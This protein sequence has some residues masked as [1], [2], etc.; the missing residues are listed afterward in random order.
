MRWFF[1]LLGLFS[2][3]L[4]W[5]VTKTPK[6]TIVL[7]DGSNELELVSATD[8]LDM[9]FRSYGVI[10]IRLSANPER[11]KEYLTSSLPALASVLQ[12]SDECFVYFAGVGT[13]DG[14]MIGDRAIKPGELEALLNNSCRGKFSVIMSGSFSG[15]Y[16]G[17]V[18]QN[19][20]RIVLTS[21]Y[22]PSPERPRI[23]YVQ[24]RKFDL[25]LVKAI[26]KIEIKT[27]A[28]LYLD[29]LKCV[30]VTEKYFRTIPVF[31]SNPTI[32][33]GRDQSQT[34]LPWRK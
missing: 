9:L 3:D 21:S 11:Q 13:D 2:S 15:T 33:Y 30:W 18:K 6:S 4:T 31:Q 20:D 5:G 27:W 17:M 28:S 22:S 8:H 34:V 7:I 26:E 1:L 23:G 24:L 25:C 19:T 29:T 32:M 16:L 14:F 10:P 12:K